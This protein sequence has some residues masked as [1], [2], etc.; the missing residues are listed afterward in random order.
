MGPG[1]GSPG[2]SGPA[3]AL[4]EGPGFIKIHFMDLES[5]LGIEDWGNPGK[6]GLGPGLD[7]GNSRQGIRKGKEINQ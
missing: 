2:K 1:L 3:R 6:P 7:N 4:R 5:G